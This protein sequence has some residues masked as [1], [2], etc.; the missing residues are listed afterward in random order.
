ML[1]PPPFC[2][3][4]LKA[5]EHKQQVATPTFDIKLDVLYVPQ[6][7]G[8]RFMLPLVGI[9]FVSTKALGFQ[10]CQPQARPP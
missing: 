9:W 3:P 8:G 6:L 7:S 10:E 2:G 5:A 4:S 1:D